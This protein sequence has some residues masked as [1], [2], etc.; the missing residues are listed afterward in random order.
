[1]FHPYSYTEGAWKP[2]KSVR[3]VVIDEK[4]SAK[5]EEMVK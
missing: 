5:A 1:M 2:A 4:A 3:R